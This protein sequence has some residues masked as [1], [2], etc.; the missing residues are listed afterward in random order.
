[1]ISSQDAIE[2]LKICCIFRGYTIIFCGILTRLQLGWKFRAQENN[3]DMNNINC[4]K[5][6]KATK[7][8]CNKQRSCSRIAYLIKL[9]VIKLL[10]YNK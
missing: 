1:M 7:A 3:D 9:R 5:F 6:I 8:V 4:N 2:F 10:L